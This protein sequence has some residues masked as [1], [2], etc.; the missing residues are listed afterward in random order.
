MANNP[1]H[2]DR[3]PF[4]EIPASDYWWLPCDKAIHKSYFM[5]WTLIV[6]TSGIVGTAMAAYTNWW[7]LLL[8][9]AFNVVFVRGWMIS[10]PT[11]GISAGIFYFW[12]SRR[13]KHNRL[14]MEER[15]R[16]RRYQDAVTSQYEGVK[17]RR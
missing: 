14:M 5:W 6:F 13:Q 11:I 2:N 7:Q 16:L 1:D 17:K 8:G 9:A 12:Y 10:L 4:H 3:E 15:I